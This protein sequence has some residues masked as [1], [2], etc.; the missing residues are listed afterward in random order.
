MA[1]YT[2]DHWA[3][4]LSLTYSRTMKDKSHRALFGAIEAVSGRF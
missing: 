2:T 4:V 3:Q 1:D